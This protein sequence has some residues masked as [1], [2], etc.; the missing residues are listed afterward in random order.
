M[1]RNEATE[2]LKEVLM[3]CRV[4]EGKSLKLMPPDADSVLSKGCQIHIEKV[5]DFITQSCLNRIARKHKL[6]VHDDG[7]YIVIYKPRMH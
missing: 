7:A 5:S 6:A 3:S 2:I 4:L 1:L